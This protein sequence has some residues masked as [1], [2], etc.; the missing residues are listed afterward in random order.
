MEEVATEGEGVLVGPPDGSEL[1]VALCTSSK[2][3]W[4]VDPP[5]KDDSR[6][7]EN[8]E[9]GLGL[10]LLRCS[11]LLVL[12]VPMVWICCLWIYASEELR[13]IES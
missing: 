2:R 3:T 8:G 10:G 7:T 13:R 5:I 9:K 4:A 1:D 11:L 6:T 12:E